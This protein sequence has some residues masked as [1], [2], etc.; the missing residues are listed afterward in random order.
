MWRFHALNVSLW[1]VISHIHIM[2][3]YVDG[4]E[5][6]Q[7]S[8]ALTCK[9]PQQRSFQVAD[10]VNTTYDVRPYMIVLSRCDEGTGCCQKGKTCQVKNFDDLE[11]RFPTFIDRKY[12]FANYTIRNHTECSCQNSKNNIKR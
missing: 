9:V 1:I 2:M 8:C 7:R 5:L 12:I 4:V 6:Y 11:V 3:S 10:L